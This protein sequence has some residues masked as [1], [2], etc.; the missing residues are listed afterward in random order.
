MRSTRARVQL[1][2]VVFFLLGAVAVG[3]SARNE[4]RKQFD[5]S[6]TAYV[7]SNACEECHQDR[8]DTWHVTFHRTMTQDATDQSVVADFDNRT[9]EYEG[10]MSRFTKEGG[11]FFVETLGPSG[12]REKLQVVRTVGSRRIQQYV[13][14]TGDRHLRIPL[15][16]NIEEKR[17]FHLNGGFLHPDGT[18]FNEHTTLWDANCIFCH[19]TKAR[20][21]FDWN[22]K[23]FNSR[24]AQLGIG[25]ESCHGPG[26]DHIARQSSTF[27]NLVVRYAGDGD[28][29]IVNPSKLPP[30]RQVQVCGH[31]HGQRVPKP[32]ERIKEFL[33]AGDPYTAGD[34]LSQYTEPIKLGDTLYDLD[35]SQ[36]FWRDG[37]PRL[38][39]YEYQALSMTPDF[40]KGGLTCIGCHN[41]HGGDPRGMISPGMRTKQACLQCHNE[42]GNDIPAHTKHTASSS[43]SDCYSCHMPKIVYGVLTVHPTHRIQSPDPSRAWQYK[44]PEA[45]T[46][47]HTNATA[48]WAAQNMASQYG[49]TAPT[50]PEGA[51]WNVA[52]NVRALLGGDV[53]QRAIAAMA[54]SD[55]RSYIEDPRARLWCVPFL[56]ITAEDSYPAIRHFAFRSIQTLIARAAEVDSSIGQSTRSL[57]PFDPQASA[58]RRREALSAWRAWWSSLDKSSIPHPGRAVP[59]DDRLEPN[60]SVVDRLLSQRDNSVVSIGE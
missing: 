43:G 16:W 14:K 54:F 21:G 10:V 51:D 37:T 5:L 38:S 25:C 13:I 30:D 24:V 42:I 53:V 60:R 15:A 59:L 7:G 56:L 52:E 2:V 41:V 45:C 26:A 34:D 27:K 23:T 18:D 3:V 32:L 6:K 40:Q 1:A 4:V 48:K 33:S 47:C 29:S 46:V 36:R 49:K 58:E 11:T 19:N 39:A 20:P 9:F 28:N 50:V 55:E 12:Q 8:H 44:M 57:P 35:F 17:W 22:Q 31:C